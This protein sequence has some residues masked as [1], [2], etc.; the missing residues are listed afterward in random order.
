MTA[1]G[2][3]P[4]DHADVPAGPPELV[5]RTAGRVTVAAVVALG[6]GLVA[7]ALTDAGGRLLLVPVLGAAGGLVLRDL[8]RGP[9][10]RADAHGLT[11]LSG[12][13][14]IGA[15]WSDVEGLRAVKDRRTPVLEVDL[16]TAVVALSGT[17]L[18]RHPEDVLEDLRELRARGSR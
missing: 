15:G 17:R 12:W 3:P 10:L 13:R 4:E 11:V 1:S 14:R 7:F 6:I 2:V 16:G 5:V 8:V 9:V 18:G